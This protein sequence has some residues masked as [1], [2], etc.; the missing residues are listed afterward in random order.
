[1]KENVFGSVNNNNNWNRK[2]DRKRLFISVNNNNS[3]NRK[4]DTERFSVV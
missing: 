4:N 3:R 2:N 1:M